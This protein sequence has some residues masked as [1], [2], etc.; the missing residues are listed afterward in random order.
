MSVLKYIPNLTRGTRVRLTADE[1]PKRGQ[2]CTIMDPL[3]NP[4]QRPE[5]QW[6]DV[7]FD[8]GSV[9]RFLQKYL[10]PVVVPLASHCA[11]DLSRT[12]S[13]VNTS[14]RKR[15]TTQVLMS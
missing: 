1:H 7:R 9:G 10:A 5:R 2:Q 3:P 15:W 12:P 6:Y 8:D 13:S 11:L 4:S 14:R